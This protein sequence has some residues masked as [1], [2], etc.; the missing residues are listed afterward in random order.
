V[1][2]PKNVEAH[3]NHGIEKVKY[4]FEQIIGTIVA[5][6]VPASLFIFCFP[7]LVIYVI[8]GPQYYPAAV[9]LQLTI[10]FSMVRPLSYQFGSTLDAIGKPHINFW[11]NAVL[12]AVN[13]LLTYV[14][15]NAY[16]GIGAAYATMIY[17]SLSFLIMLF[18]LKKYIRIKLKNIMRYAWARYSDL[19]DYLRGQF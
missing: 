3:E 1:L 19:Y 4:Y 7:R 18:I 12:M 17:Y 8:A 5:F 15:L 9:I 13:L 14:F 11:V 6:V 10:L 16:G 2:F